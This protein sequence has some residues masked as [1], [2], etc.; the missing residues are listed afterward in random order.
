MEWT[1]NY[2]EEEG[3]VSAKT[4]GIMNW[5]EH[6]RFAE[7]L[8]PL[9]DKYGANK[10]LI[11]FRDMVPDFTILQVDELPKM[12]KEMGVG[13]DLKIASIY[14]PASPHSHEFEFFNNVA[15]LLSIMV[16]QFDNPDEAMAW[17]KS[18]E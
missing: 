7:E 11:D 6:K 4:S 15:N 8:Y 16:K 12:L 3:I 10:I 5:D 9:A 2:L 14:D 18:D 1:I 13:P 17:L